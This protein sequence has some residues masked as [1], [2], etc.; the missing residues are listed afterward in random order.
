MCHTLYWILNGSKL[1]FLELI[2]K[3]KKNESFWNIT[4]CR[5]FEYYERILALKLKLGDNPIWY[6]KIFG[7]SFGL[8]DPRESTSE[9]KKFCL[10][11]IYSCQ[12]I[13]KKCSQLK[14]ENSQ[15]FTSLVFLQNYFFRRVMWGQTG[16]VWPDL[17][18]C[19]NTNK[20]L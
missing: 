5:F 12:K 1:R 4:I 6:L 18:C 10:N 19:F 20:P 14:P 9:I 7:L 13:W 17:F 8:C 2:R 15:N 16:F 3:F 11:I